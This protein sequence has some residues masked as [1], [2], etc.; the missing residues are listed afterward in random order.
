MKNSRGFTLIELLVV[1]AIIGILSSVV[2]AS[3]SSA[4]N[5]GKD[6]AVKSG[7]SSLRT[8]MEID[9]NGAN[10]GAAATYATAAGTNAACAV[11]NFNASTITP[12]KTNL[13]GNL[14]VSTNIVCSVDVAHA[15]NPAT[16]WAIAAILPSGAGLQCI[17]SSGNAQ[18]Y[19]AVTTVGSITTA[20]V[21]NGSCI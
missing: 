16:K 10:Y 5:K 19:P 15:T 3:L 12:I 8:Q 9:S 4:R 18:N 2:L 11:G 13:T 6:A 7:L 17:D 20:Q 21:N 1:I 14:A